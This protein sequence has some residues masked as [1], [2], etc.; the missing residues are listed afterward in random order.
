MLLKVWKRKSVFWGL[1]YWEL[2]SSPHSL[3]MMHI[4]KNI[5]ES[6]LGTLFDMP[7]KS[8]DGTRARQDLKD[9]GIREELKPASLKR[10]KE[11]AKG[12]NIAIADETTKGKTMTK[13]KE[14]Y[15]TPACFTLDEDELHQLFNCLDGIKVPFGYSRLI[16]RY[17]DTKKQ[18]FSNMKSHDC[19]VMMTQL[20]PV[21]LRGIM[22]DH[23]RNTLLDFCNIFDVLSRKSI[24]MRH[25]TRLQEEIITILCELEIYFPRH[26]L[27]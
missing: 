27:M 24:S 3:D 17:L 9:I 21:A 8:K 2:L 18:R 25:L 19:H 10:T 14:D 13:N 7:E 22:D 4:T 16:C 20:L 5:C 6:L 26:S 23:I 1:K 12:K 15:C 11:I